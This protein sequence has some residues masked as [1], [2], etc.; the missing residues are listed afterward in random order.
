MNWKHLEG[1]GHK[2]IKILSRHVVEGQRK[3]TRS[4]SYVADDSYKIWNRNLQNTRVLR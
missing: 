2:L 4:L 3:N 1:N